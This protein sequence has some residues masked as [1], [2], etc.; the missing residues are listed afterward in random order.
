MKVIA[1]IDLGGTAINYTIVTMQEQF[2]I[3]GLCEHPALSTQGPAVCL[4]QIEDGL[5]IAVEKAGVR[6][7]DVAA[8]GLDT[9][10]PA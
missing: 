9:P 2:L 4:G 1:G 7:D 5:K 10:G 3:E 6:L 8:V